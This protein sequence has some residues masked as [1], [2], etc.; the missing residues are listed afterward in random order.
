M[1]MT[2]R[3]LLGST[4]AAGAGW[5]ASPTPPNILFLISDDHSWTD[6]GCF[7]NKAVTSSN[8]D[9]LAARGVRFDNCY[10][11][12]PQC[13]PNRSGILTGQ[14]PHATLT[15]RLHTPMPE[16]QE[17]FLEPLKERGYFAGAFRKVHQG[18]QFDKRWDFYGTAKDP[19]EKFFATRPKDR[20]FFLHVG[21]T[22]PHRPYFAGGW[23]PP[24]D[25]G[26]VAVPPFLPDAPAVR[27][28]LAIYYDYIA[29]MDAMCGELLALLDRENLTGNTL[30]MF[31][32]DNGMAFPRAKGTLYDPGIRVPFMASW[33]GRIRPGGLRNELVSHA[34]IAATLLE[35][36]GARPLRRTEG[37]SFLPLLEGRAMEPRKEI[38]AERNW[39]DNFDPI[40][41]VRTDRW[42]LILNAALHF[43]YRPALDIEESPSWKTF[44]QMAGRRAM[45]PEH[46][47]L[48]A[49]NRPALELYDLQGDPNEFTNRAGLPETR[50]VQEDLTRRLSSWMEQTR[51]YLPPASTREGLSR[52]WPVTL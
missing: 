1:D 46:L 39:H 44:Q 19:W 48:M 49:P 24:H 27:A 20:P 35:A 21:F 33:P 25:P 22:E 10:V 4:A 3:S 9:R 30:V 43:P 42:K 37:R 32:G 36:A 6:L 51:D 47:S 16:W 14:T 11:T 29:R 8:L 41:C 52:S 34:D 7:G 28:D 17:T 12:S 45:K 2:R 13:S 15:S 23:K 38:F 50:D 31:T 18:P 5:G 40:R 26:S